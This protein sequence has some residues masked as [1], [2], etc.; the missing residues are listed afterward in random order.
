[1][2]ELGQ[3]L[4]FS[5][6]YSNTTRSISSECF[7]FLGGYCKSSFPGKAKLLSISHKIALIFS[8]FPLSA[9]VVE[10]P[11]VQANGCKGHLSYFNLFKRYVS[12]FCTSSGTPLP[13]DKLPTCS[14]TQEIEKIISNIRP[15]ESNYTLIRSIEEQRKSHE[16]AK[17]FVIRNIAKIG[18]NVSYI[19]P[20]KIAIPNCS[21]IELHPL[22]PNVFTWENTNGVKEDIIND[23]ASTENTLVI[24]G[25]AS[26]YNGCEAPSKYTVKPGHAVDVYMDDHTQGPQAQLAFDPLQVELINCGGNLKFNGLCK[27]LD[28]KTKD[29]VQSG[30]FTPNPENIDL[31]IDQLRHKG[32]HMEFP[33]IGNI[34]TGGSKMV[35]QI[36]ASAPAFGVYC[37]DLEDIDNEKKVEVQ[38]LCAFLSYTAQFQQVL[39]Y[40][41]N[42]H[43]KQIN[44]KPTVPGLGV[45]GNDPIVI[46]KAFYA[47]AKTFEG[48]LEAR[49]VNVRLQIWKGNE[50]HTSAKAMAQTLNLTKYRQQI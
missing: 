41:Q 23:G 40:A 34:P 38:Y 24:Y 25:V 48:Q 22:N 19:T 13:L 12:T 26:Q 28:E 45:F 4:A 29:T 30:Y 42:I 31:I 27:V 1:M 5:T 15:I 10:G 20:P 35:Y 47:A 49:K 21:S 37:N 6:I 44:F 50:I 11:A 43:E 7:R 39:R 2:D 8:K 33:C 16:E 14:R 9:S 36:L 17:R 18:G 3:S 32:Q 46:A